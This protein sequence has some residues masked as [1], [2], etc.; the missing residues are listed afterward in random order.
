MS[1]RKQIEGASLTTLKALLV[2]TLAARNSAEAAESWTAVASLL[3]QEC[4]LRQQIDV[5]EGERTATLIDVPS[6][7][8][9][10]RLVAAL[11]PLALMDPAILAAM[12]I[13]SVGDA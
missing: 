1:H 8:V 9:R 10:R 6:R 11:R 7:E 5:L 2:P 3:R 13:E 12:A 4:D